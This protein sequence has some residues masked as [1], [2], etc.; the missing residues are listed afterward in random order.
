M[1]LD[2]DKL[3]VLKYVR[4]SLKEANMTDNNFQKQLVEHK[5]VKLSFFFVGRGGG[6]VI[7]AISKIRDSVSSSGA[8][9]N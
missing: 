2:R 8:F 6:G 4:Q 9:C 3:D 1:Q 7:I 5:K